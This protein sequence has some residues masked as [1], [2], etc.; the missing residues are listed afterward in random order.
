MDSKDNKST[1]D[2]VESFNLDI[3]LNLTN[4]LQGHRISLCLK[5]NMLAST[6]AHSLLFIAHERFKKGQVTF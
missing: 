4:K 5:A 2:V 3:S 6:K 1:L